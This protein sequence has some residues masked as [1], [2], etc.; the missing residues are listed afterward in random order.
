M[1]HPERCA[2][3]LAKRNKSDKIETK[4][5]GGHENGTGTDGQPLDDGIKKFQRV[6]LRL[7]PHANRSR[8]GE[9]KL[10]RVRKICFYPKAV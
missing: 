9:G 5:C 3:S 2:I 8:N 1:A 6:K 10:G 7:L 4:K